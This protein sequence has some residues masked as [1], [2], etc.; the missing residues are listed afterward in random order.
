[1]TMTMRM[2]RMTVHHDGAG[3]AR[4]S[5]RAA[6]LAIRT[7]RAEQRALPRNFVNCII[8]QKPGK[9]GSAVENE[10]KMVKFAIFE[11][12]S[13]AHARYFVAEYLASATN[14]LVSGINNL[15]SATKYL[16]SG[17]NNLA[18]GINNLMSAT[19]NLASGVKNLASDVNN[20]ECRANNL[21]CEA[22]NPG[23]MGTNRVEMA[24]A[25]RVMRP[26]WTR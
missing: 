7:R 4:H 10:S 11:R 16:V 17:I 19:E 24:G 18:S 1:M 8:P 5:V 26:T 13:G 6:F 20:L 9:M 14:N 3:R 15:A 22:E 25:G 23:F 2:S 21:D 12:F